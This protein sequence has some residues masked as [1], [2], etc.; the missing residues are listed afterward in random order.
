MDFPETGFK[1]FF[2]HILTTFG[3]DDGNEQTFDTVSYIYIW[4]LNK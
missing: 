3:Q 4:S 2:E 1:I